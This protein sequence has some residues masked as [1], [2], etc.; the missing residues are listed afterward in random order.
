LTARHNR[1]A[2]LFALAATAVCC[3]SSAVNGSA[4]ARQ[5]ALNR[6]TAASPQ[7]RLPLPARP[8][9]SSV[10][11]LRVA[12]VK[13]PALAPVS[14]DVALAPCSAAAKSWEPERL[15][16]LGVYPAD[17]AASYSV[18]AAAAL[19]RL[20]NR[21]VADLKDVCLQVG[22]RRLHERTPADALEITLAAPEW[23]EEK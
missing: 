11:V 18:A 23:R 7:V 17:Q 2:S 15:A 20:R 16:S 14:L 22:L 1:I 10:L 13:N 5:P 9:S 4:Q 3:G 12:D 21:G 19:D 6:L 8:T